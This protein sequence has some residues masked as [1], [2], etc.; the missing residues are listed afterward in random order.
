LRALLSYGLVLNWC[1]LVWDY[2]EHLLLKEQN[3]QW[4]FVNARLV[5][6]PGKISPIPYP[7]TIVS[8]KTQEGIWLKRMLEE[9]LDFL[10]ELD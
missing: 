4:L 2:E 3:N 10:S 8:C 9:G 5:D 6:F 1:A 7:N